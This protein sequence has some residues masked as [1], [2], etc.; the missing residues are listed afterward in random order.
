M[1]KRIANRFKD[2]ETHFRRLLFS[3]IFKSVNWFSDNYGLKNDEGLSCNR[4]GEVVPFDVGF[5]KA[6]GV[7]DDVSLAVITD[8]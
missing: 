8:I 4:Y 6:N 1:T 3:D 7:F 2:S 5:I